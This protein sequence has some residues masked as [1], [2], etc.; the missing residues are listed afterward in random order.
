M[1]KTPF[2]GLTRLA[3]NDPLSTDNSSFQAKNPSITDR[4]LQIGALTHRHNALP[5]LGNPSGYAP[6]VSVY[7]SGGS[8]PADTDISVGF[9]LNNATGGETELSDVTTVS[10]QPPYNPPASP[11]TAVVDYGA[12]ALL[13]ATYYYAVTLVD[14][15]GGETALG[16]YATGDRLPGYA[17]G[18][19]LLS[20]LNDDFGVDGAVAW[21]LYRA[22]G[23]GEFQFLATGTS[24]TFTDDG[25]VAV[26]CDVLP[27]DDFN[28]T[29]NEGNR[30]E[31]IVP[32]GVLISE[33]ETFNVY[34]CT[35][36]D[37]T[38]GS[39]VGTYPVASAM[40]VINVNS[41]ALGAGSPPDVSS[42]IP[43]AH[44]IDPD[45]E[46][47][48]WH[49]KRPVATVG[50]L[51]LGSATEAGDVRV[52]LSDSDPYI[53]DQASSGW[54]LFST[55]GISQVQKVGDTLYASR[56]K[57]RFQASGAV[58]LAVSDDGTGQ[59]TV[60]VFASGTASAAAGHSIQD[61]GSPL[62][63]RPIIDFVG[64]GVTATDAGGKTVVTIPGAASA[65]GGHVVEDEGTPL[66][67][68]SNLDF[69]G[70]GV[71]ATDAGGKT[72]ITIPGAA[73]TAS[74]L[75][76]TGGHII[77]DEEVDLTQR[78]RLDFTGNGVVVTDDAGAS[79]T[80]VTIQQ[81]ILPL[82][83]HIVE[84]E[85]S[86]VTQ[87]GVLNF[88]GAGVTVSDGPGARTTVTIPGGGGGGS[89]LASAYTTVE[90]EGTPLTERDTINFIGA[91]VTVTDSGGKT[92]VN[93]PGGG[94]GS[95]TVAFGSGY[96]AVLQHFQGAQNHG[97]MLDNIVMGTGQ[98]DQN[99]F[100]YPPLENSLGVSFA[101]AGAYTVIPDDG[102]Y[103]LEV[104]VQVLN[105]DS[106]TYPRWV[107]SVSLQA[108]LG[109][110]TDWQTLDGFFVPVD[111]VDPFL[112]LD[113][114]SV[115]LKAGPVFLPAG[116]VVRVWGELQD[117]TYADIAWTS[118]PL[119]WYGTGGPTRTLTI[120]KVG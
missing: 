96:T 13:A 92:Q 100:Y 7:A 9:T 6:L 60:T 39:L 89:G 68:R 35:D 90:D 27:P 53:Y 88:E 54:V 43:G 112:V 118:Q 102:I 80:V 22:I 98:P 15:S 116:T 110:G 36:G 114:S 99:P 72:V 107:S 78:P 76:G 93:I 29:T 115:H 81:P 66:T 85:Q 12:G 17:S 55:G 101:S 52:V 10:T 70:A 49:W 48:D 95:G 108:D 87:R 83:G 103:L 25:S 63:Q 97:A 71:T 46:L 30:L 106:G 4:L 26:N 40:T 18:R 84:D 2:A 64:G 69:V 82:A 5:A 23:G 24:D 86:A 1:D 73:G 45:S 3:P 33:A 79:A 19:V 34:L 109:N 56:T 37:F 117:D 47:L 120:Q 14:G 61:E 77:Q 51:P 8:I 38:T 32:S 104:L 67:Q 94:G 57:L 105:D 11:I 65:V 91:G 44:K 20:G 74:G 41:L 113:S 111:L 59:S 50:D 42:C 21:R 62:T 28:A 75:A 58:T 16:P 119:P 31:V